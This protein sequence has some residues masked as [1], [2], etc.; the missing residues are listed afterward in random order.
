MFIYKKMMNIFYFSFYLH[1]LQM[2]PSEQVINYLDCTACGGA[3][4][5]IKQ[6]CEMKCN[7]GALPDSEWV[8]IKEALPLHAD[9]I[10][11][12]IRLDLGSSVCQTLS[13]FE[14]PADFKDAIHNNDCNEPLTDEQ[15][16]LLEDPEV[17]Q[18]L[19]SLHW[20]RGCEKRPFFNNV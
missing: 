19:D 11:K 15:K 1:Y 6:F 12:M 16:V 17:F 4:E 14:G 2:N 7:D 13:G 10:D 3:A 9:I 5:H 8:I 20:H 18:F